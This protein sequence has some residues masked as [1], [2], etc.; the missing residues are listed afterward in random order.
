MIAES[1]ETRSGAALLP[2]GSSWV[3]NQSINNY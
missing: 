1:S 2:G 3:L